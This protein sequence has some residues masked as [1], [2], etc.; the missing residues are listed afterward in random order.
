MADEECAAGIVVSGE[1]KKIYNVVAMGGPDT[2]DDGA[3]LI[4]ARTECGR[5]I[6]VMQHPGDDPLYEVSVSEVGSHHT[7]RGYR[8]RKGSDAH[9]V[10]TGYSKALLEKFNGS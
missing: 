9:R 5:T 7:E 2:M 1:I 3:I 6:S 4:Q 8:G 10:Y